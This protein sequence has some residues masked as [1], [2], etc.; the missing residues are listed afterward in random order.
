MNPLGAEAVN[1]AADAFALL[2][3]KEQ[4]FRGLSYEQ[5]GK[6]GAKVQGGGQ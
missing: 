5:L 2:A 4:A 3:Q 1:S 6:V